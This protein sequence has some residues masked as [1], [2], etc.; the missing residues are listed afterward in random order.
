MAAGTP[1]ILKL[2]GSALLAEVPQVDAGGFR[3]QDPPAH[4]RS[5]SE[6]DFWS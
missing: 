1:T 4:P 5:W 3:P 2:A 6:E